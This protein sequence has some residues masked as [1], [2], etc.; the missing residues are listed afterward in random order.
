M[1][2]RRSSRFE[3][4]STSLG[5]SVNPVDRGKGS[6][7]VWSTFKLASLLSSFEGGGGLKIKSVVSLVLP[8]VLR[9]EELWKTGI[10]GGW[11][12]NL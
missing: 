1:S 6:V 5:F 9:C 3:L 11:A 2:A 4:V 8:P 7:V 12:I 10:G